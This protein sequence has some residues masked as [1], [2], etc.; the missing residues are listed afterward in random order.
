M[1]NIHLS[2]LSPFPVLLACFLF[3][4]CLISDLTAFSITMVSRVAMAQD[5]TSIDLNEQGVAAVNK[6]NFESAER[7]FQ[8]ALAADDGNITAVYNLAGMYLT[9]RKHEEALELLK[10]YVAR[11]PHDAG[12]HVRLG[13]AYFAS[14]NLPDALE[15][16]E[17][18]AERD[19]TFPGVHEKLGT[20]YALMQ[21]LDEAEAALLR[22]TQND[23]QNGNILSNLS[24]VFLGND[25]PQKAISTA[26]RA[27]QIQPTADIYVT[28]GTAYEILEDYPN[29]LIAFQ[30]AV[31][32]GDDRPELKK[33]IKALEDVTSK[34]N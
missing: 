20:I 11:V 33:K 30:R 9:N 31:D 13:D 17:N 22:A 21:R 10:L 14:R 1:Q 2:R 29:S 8:R 26:R 7:Y 4:A 28:L 18:G 15:H 3:G 5:Q 19:D 6:Q 23:P 34:E 32:L 12:L 16:Y 27:L 24:S 25:K